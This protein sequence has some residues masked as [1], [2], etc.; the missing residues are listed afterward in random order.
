M[1]I[2]DDNMAHM[3]K[4]DLVV[5]GAGPAGLAVSIAA[6]QA[7]LSHVVVDQSSVG[8][9]IRRFPE[10]MTFL[11]TPEN[12]E[13]GG[14]PFVT[15]NPKPT[16][17]E[18][19]TYYCRVVKALELP[20]E[21]FVRV[22]KIEGAAPNFRVHTVDIHGTEKT[23]EAR[24]VVAATGAHSR[25]RSLGIPGED[26]PHVS[27]DFDDPYRV[28]GR[29]VLIVGGGNSAVEAALLLLRA[30]VEVSI[31]YRRADFQEK[32][33][34]WLLPDI[35]N[36]IREGAIGGYM[37]SEVLSIGRGTVQLRL[38]DGSETEVEADFVYLLI[39]YLADPGFLRSLGITVAEDG[40]PA[41][42]PQTRESNVPGI[43][44]AGRICAG[45]DGNRIFI[46]NSREHGE[47]IVGHLLAAGP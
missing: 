8:S 6:R 31:S 42:D 25:P 5:I 2:Y 44:V 17:A 15:I 35:R 41:H 20:V 33:K 22:V 24:A 40:T 1:A 9:T 26:L 10:G 4:R 19:L 23:L 27:H 46:E 37:P 11:S 3:E 21:P 29:R 28:F 32:I 30:G 7:G 36:R 12:L 14:I 38:G 47:A 39:G 18:A 13:I 45:D 16:K 43:Y 34:Y